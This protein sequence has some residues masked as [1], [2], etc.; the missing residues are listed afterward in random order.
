MFE[1][2]LKQ[3]AAIVLLNTAG[4][5]L[6]PAQRAK[7]EQYM[8]EGGNAVVVHRAAIT[9]PKPNSDAVLI[10]ASS[11]PISVAFGRQDLKFIRFLMLSLRSMPQESPRVE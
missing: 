3:Y 5:E 6:N 9:P 7:F 11:A 8:R 10:V 2:D 4:E 1:G